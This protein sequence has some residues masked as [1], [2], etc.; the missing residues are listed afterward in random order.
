MIEP[1]VTISLHDF[2]RLRDA[3]DVAIELLSEIVEREP[4]LADERRKRVNHFLLTVGGSA[5]EAKR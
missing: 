2:D 4:E 5:D 3:L 1:T